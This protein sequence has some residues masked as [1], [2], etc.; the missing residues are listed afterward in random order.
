M[1]SRSFPEPE[2]PFDHLDLRDLIMSSDDDMQGHP[3]MYTS[4][5]EALEII[6]KRNINSQPEAGVPADRR[7]DMNQ[8]E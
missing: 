1:L 5:D 4:L 6:K 8:P 3:P 2:Q 7:R